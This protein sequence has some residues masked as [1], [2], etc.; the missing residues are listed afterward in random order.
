[1]L[2]NL[3]K[4]LKNMNLISMVLK[5]MKLKSMKLKSMNLK[6]MNTSIINIIKAISI[7]KTIKKA[8]NTSIKST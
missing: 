7:I 4:K 8:K 2:L 5:S 3:K 6:S 1:M